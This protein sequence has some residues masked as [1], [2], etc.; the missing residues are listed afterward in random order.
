MK[1]SSPYSDGCP[2]GGGFEMIVISGG[3]ALRE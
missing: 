1:Y 2:G 3:P